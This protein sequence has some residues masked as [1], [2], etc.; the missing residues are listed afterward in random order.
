[1]NK[2]IPIVKSI[3]EVKRVIIILFIK[4][5][6]SG[7]WDEKTLRCYRLSYLAIFCF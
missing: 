3:M 7:D 1:M 4:Y 5:R 6:L 2:W